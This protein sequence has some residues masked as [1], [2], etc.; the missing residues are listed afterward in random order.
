M[1]TYTLS[2]VLLPD[3]L[4]EFGLHYGLVRFENET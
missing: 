4:D 2:K 3:G 1:G